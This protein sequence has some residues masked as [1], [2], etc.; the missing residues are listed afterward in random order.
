MVV[1]ERLYRAYRNSN[2]ISIDSRTVAQGELFFALS[3]ENFDGNVFAQSALEQGASCAVVSNPAIKGKN[4][5]LVEDCLES[6]QNLAAY[7][8]DKLN[9]PIIAITGS[10]GKTT[11]KELMNVVLSKRFN[12]S[13]TK[14]NLNNHIG[15]PLSL[16]S[17][18]K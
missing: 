17:I 14:G 8:R 11:T 4:I 16:L 13:A 10:N 3:G 15:V 5:I 9:I 1:I 7:H 2:G 18:G 12:T 6:L